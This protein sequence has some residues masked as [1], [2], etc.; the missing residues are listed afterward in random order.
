MQVLLILRLLYQRKTLIKIL[1]NIQHHQ[2]EVKLC[3]GQ[4]VMI[5]VDFQVGLFFKRSRLRLFEKG[6]FF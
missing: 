4:W 3:Q 1:R 5:L 2:I 6:L